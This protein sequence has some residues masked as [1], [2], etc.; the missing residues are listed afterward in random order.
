MN[1]NKVFDV[2]VIGAGPAGSSAAQELARSSKDVLIVEKDREVGR[3]VLCA[4]GIS[5]N[6]YEIVRPEKGVATIIKHIGIHVEGKINFYIHSRS[7]FGFIL[8]RK[9]F[10]RHLFER[11]VKA[12]AET[13]I[14]ARFMDLEKD[15][16]LYKIAVQFKSEI[17]HLYG[18]SIVGADGPGSGVGQ[19]AGFDFQGN[20]LVTHYCAQVYL[21]HD[22]IDPET[23][24]FYYDSNITPGGYAWVFPKDKGFANV[25]LGVTTGWEQAEKGLK[26]FL[27][28]YF[29]EGKVC[30]FL[31]GVVPSGGME[32]ELEKD[33]VFLVGDAARLADPMSGG[34]I[35]NA[36]ISGRLAAEAI[37]SGKRN[38]Y[39]ELLK[40]HL[41]RDYHISKIVRKIFYDLSTEEL[42]SIFGEIKKGLQDKEIEAL[43]PG[44]ALTIVLRASP[45]VFSYLLSRGGRFLNEF[46]R[47]IIP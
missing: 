7:G 2:I 37:N 21:Y 25:G 1:L 8:E 24:E 43:N 33:G 13:L 30:G 35:A 31:K 19:K 22:L 38:K 12:G 40:S 28:K 41:G 46:V 20:D 32:F 3:N 16:E 11:A 9:I 17:L 4:E 27:E 10:D 5:K 14:G 47:E 39:N 44:T 23:I 26:M 34:G 36:Y 15:G 42:V 29:P 18:K 45:R 6:F